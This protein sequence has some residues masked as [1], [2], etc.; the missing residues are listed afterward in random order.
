M[1]WWP[2]LR[3]WLPVDGLGGLGRGCLHGW[4]LGGGKLPS[5]PWVWWWAAPDGMVMQGTAARASTV[6]PS[7]VNHALLSEGHHPGG[8]R[9]RVNPG[10]K[11]VNGGLGFDGGR[12]WQET[13]SVDAL[14]PGD[15]QVWSLTQFYSVDFSKSRIN[16]NKCIFNK[17]TIKVFVSC[18]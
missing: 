13:T 6:A 1:S 10:H 5:R 3:R 2:Y 4:T 18:C 12:W 15:R 8:S 14:C 11:L 7:E 17:R 16:V 9:W